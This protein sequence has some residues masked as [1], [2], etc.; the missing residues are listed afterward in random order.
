MKNIRLARSRVFQL[1][2][3]NDPKQVLHVSRCLYGSGKRFFPGSSLVLPWFFPGSP[4]VPPGGGVNRF[5]GSPSH[6]APWPPRQGRTREEPGR[7]HGRT[8][9]LVLPWFFPGSSLVLPGFLPGGGVNRFP[10]SSPHPAPWPPR[11]GRPRE[12]P[13]RN[14][15]RTKPLVLPW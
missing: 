1:K 4:R 7:N 10:G 14:Q 2:D 9:P 12:E 8:R 11:Q 6:P 5:P 15:G 3:Q 13:G